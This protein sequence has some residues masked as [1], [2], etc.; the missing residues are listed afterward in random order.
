[1]KNKIPLKC[2]LFKQFSPK[3]FWNLKLNDVNKLNFPSGKKVFL[4]GKEE[5]LFSLQIW[6]SNFLNVLPQNNQRIF[7][8]L[9]FCQNSLFLY[10]VSSRPLGPLF[11]ICILK[12]LFLVINQIQLGFIISCHQDSG[13]APFKTRTLVNIEL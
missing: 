3:A 2:V 5:G 9:C 11:L 10:T 7:S 8:T 13:N 12:I 6:Q 4:S 1:M